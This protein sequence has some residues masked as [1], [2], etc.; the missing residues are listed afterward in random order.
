MILAHHSIFSLYGFWLPN[1]PRGS[2]SNYVAVYD[3]LRHRQA[4]KVTTRNSVARRRVDP[5]WKPAALQAIQHPPIVLS[6][7][8]A[9]AVADGF[10]EAIGQGRY[11]IHAC[12]ILPD[13]VHMVVGR[14]VRDIRKIVGHLK[15]KATRKLRTSGRRPADGRPIWGDHGWNVALNTVADVQRAIRY[16]EA[17][18][19]KE[20][21]KVQHWNFVSAFNE[22]AAP[23]VRHSTASRRI[24]GAALRSHLRR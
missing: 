22:N 23:A 9:L 8:Q 7:I 2:G 1:D 14:H 16:V 3:L 20:G 18:P 15:S 17:N 12:A 5:A 24:G 21:K 10:H 13:H 6:G 4:T 19:Q 11:A